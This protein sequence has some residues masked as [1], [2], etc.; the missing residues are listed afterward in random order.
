ME[1]RTGVV[2]LQGEPMTLLGDD[3]A[4]GALVTDFRLIGPDLSPVGWSELKGRPVLFNVVP[5]L[6]TEVC[7][8]QTRRFNEELAS[9]PD[10]LTVVTVS[11][12]LPFAQSRFAE[13]EGIRHRI[14]SD[15]RDLDFARVFGVAIKELRLLTRSIFIVD[16]S[17]RVIYREIVPDLTQHPDY[18][19]ALEV[20]RKLG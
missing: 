3:L 16:A 17:G 15:Y 9:L 18:R 7:A 19:K 12:D 2:T 10:T 8:M 13:R 20:A 4:P 1:E 14:L 6:D 11:A 5:S